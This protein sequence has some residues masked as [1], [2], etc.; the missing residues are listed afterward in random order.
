L[1]QIILICQIP[2]FNIFTQAVRG[3]VL[4]SAPSL[5]EGDGFMVTY[6]ELFTFVIMICAIITLVIHIYKK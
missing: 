6:D 4:P 2:K 5:V 3:T 1:Y